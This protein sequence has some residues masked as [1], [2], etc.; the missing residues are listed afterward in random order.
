MDKTIQ[1]AFEE[2]MADENLSM[3]IEEGRVV[4]D[5]GMFIPA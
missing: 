2:H 3:L 1:Y 4:E 5:G